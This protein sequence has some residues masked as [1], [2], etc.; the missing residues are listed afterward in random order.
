MIFNCIFCVEAVSKIGAFGLYTPRSIEYVAYLQVVT[1]A[2]IITTA[3]TTAL[4]ITTA[5]V[6]IRRDQSSVWPICR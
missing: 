6:C 4:V 5:S 3:Y 2:L 1:T